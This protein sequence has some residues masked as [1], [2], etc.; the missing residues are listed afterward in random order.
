MKIGFFMDDYFP[1]MNGVIYVMDNYAKLLGKSC[2][3]VVIV[4]EIDKNYKEKSRVFL[5]NTMV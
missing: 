2:E 1:S 5:F 4:P 3:V